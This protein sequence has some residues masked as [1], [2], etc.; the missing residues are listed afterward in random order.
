MSDVP[1]ISPAVVDAITNMLLSAHGMQRPPEKA[2]ALLA[3]ICEFH[4]RNL[5][6]P[7]REIVA[8]AIGASVATVDAALSTRIQE[9]YITP[10]IETR[11]GNVQR[12]N[13]TI[14]ERYYVPSEEL[15]SLVEKAKRNESRARKRG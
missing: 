14:R 12:R 10:R 13:S 6:F 9:G 11:D 8:R 5:P 15:L 4:K 3:I 1:A 7:K 2:A